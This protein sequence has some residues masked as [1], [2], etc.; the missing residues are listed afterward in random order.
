M[1]KHFRELFRRLAAHD[2][3]VSPVKCQFGKTQ[4]E[5]L[6]HTVTKDGIKPLPEKVDAINAYPAPSTDR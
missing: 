6:G 4:I 2:L 3:V 1:K 5:F